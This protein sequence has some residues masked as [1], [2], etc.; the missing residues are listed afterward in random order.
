M[1]GWIIKICSDNDLKGVELPLPRHAATF[2]TF[3]KILLYADDITMFLKDKKDLDRALVVINLFSRF[4]CLEINERKTEA[5]WLG[6][7]RNRQDQYYNIKWKQKVKIVGIVFSNTVPASSL[8]ENW[9]SRIEK[10]KR[11]I[12]LWSR[13][14]LSLSG[15]LCIIKTF[16]LSQYVYILQSLAIPE[17]VLKEINT[18]LFKFLWKKKF[19]N[20]RA[21]EKVKR[22]VMCKS[23]EHG[24]VAMI[25]MID[26]QNSFLLSWAIKLQEP[27]HSKWQ[28]V[29]TFWYSFI[30]LDLSCFESNASTKSFIGLAYIKSVFWQRVLCSWL[31]HKHKL[32]KTAQHTPLYDQCIWNN[33]N[34][35]YKQKCLFFK[36]WLEANICYVR[37]IL[38]PTGIRTLDYIR[39]KIG[40]RPNLQ[41]EYNA[42]CTALR[43][44][45]AVQ[46][47]ELDQIEHYIVTEPL[48]K[49]PKLIRHCLVN[50]SD[51]QPCC[52][53]F[54]NR[55]Y[56]LS[57]SRS[58]W[59]VALQTTKEERLRLLH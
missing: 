40:N 14:N 23:Q 50:A 46:A 20:T 35:A 16:L 55:K 52:I 36:S 37:D 58:H 17:T 45:T 44:R 43:S 3:L 54:W 1:L 38:T 31:T 10:I 6:S 27:T 7:E 29:P 8:E 18:I 32:V 30:G 24:G 21:F 59:L 19:N 12:S 9:S 47:L 28:A 4:S 39:A 48:P 34:I 42:L 41:F 51:S 2:S 15:K 22:S 56:D 11:I 49:T 25:D 13:R 26:M 33:T 57:L 5:M 53:N